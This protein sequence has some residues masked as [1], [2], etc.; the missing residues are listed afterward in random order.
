MLTISAPIEIKA[1]TTY[2]RDPEAFYQRITGNYSL[3]ETRIEEEDL[4]HIASTPPE[5]Y[6]TEGEGMTSILTQ[7][8]RN[9]TNLQ[10]VEI[11]NNVLNRIVASADVELTYQDKVFITDAL[12]KLGVKDDRKFMNAFYRMAEETKNTNT[13]INI[14]LQRA[15]ELKELVESIESRQKEITKQEITAT[16]SERENYLYNS[17]MKRLKTGAIYQIVSNFNRSVTENEIENNEYS[18]SDQSYTAQHILLSVLRERAGVSGEN[19]V[20]LNSNVYEED[21]ENNENGISTVRNQITAAVLMDLLKNIYHTAYDRFYGRTENYYRFEDTFFKSSDHTFLRLLNNT[22]ESYINYLES[23]EYITENNNLTSTEIELLQ[24]GE[25]GQMSEEELLQ[26]TQ[27]INEINVQNEKRRQEYERAFEKIREKHIERE[28]TGGMEKT[29]QDGVLALSNP[30]ELKEVLAQRQE[31]RQKK[32]D[33]IMREMQ[34]LF[35]DQASEIYQ[36]I[37]QYYQGNT[38]LIQNNVLRPAEVGELIYDINEAERAETEAAT[39]QE[40]KRSKE[41]EEFLKS[42]KEARAQEKKPKRKTE[43][44]EQP[45]ETVHRRTNALTTEELDEQISELQNN[46]SK[47]I[48]K[49]IRSESVTEDRVINKQEVITNQTTSNNISA[50]DIQK[51]IESGVKREMNTISNQVINKLERQM[52]NEKA[53]RGYN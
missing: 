43:N 15:G 38:T 10:K 4:L 2:L 35:P 27:T 42:L 26:I 34:T 18:I 53:R 51:L 13:L 32:Q 52:R 50:F 16:E 5:I 11:L 19:L 7:N 24:R 3:M 29:R 33:L 44:F 25:E 22:D 8:Q 31:K 40:Q 23:E 30:E 47:Q 12:Y 14:Y 1:K 46:I 21:I 6:V 49:E 45:V 41:A 39:R 9:E 20:F 36:L 48:N 28:T 17:V 37:D